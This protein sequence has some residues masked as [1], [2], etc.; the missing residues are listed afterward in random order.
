MK[1]SLDYRVLGLLACCLSFTGHAT[2]ATIFNPAVP[3]SSPSTTPFQLAANGQAL[4]PV[5]VSPS[6]S[7]ATKA[8]A[9]ELAEYLGRI[10]GAKFEVKSGDGSNGIVLGTLREFPHPELDKPLEIRDRF[11]GREAFAIR[12]ETKR[13][14]LI[15]AT[16]LGAS[17]AVFR[18]LE[19]LGCRWFFPAREWEVVPSQ[20][21]LSFGVNENSRPTL[22]AR[23]IW[24]GGGL[25]RDVHGNDGARS[26]YEYE[27]WKRHNRL[28][29]SLTMRNGHAWQAII[30]QN[31]AE[32]DKHPE[33]Y[34]LIQDK[35]GS[36]RRD[37]RPEAKL[38]VTNPAVQQMAVDYA[39]ETF[40][41][42]PD[43]EM[44]SMEPSDGGGWS[45]S[46]EAK[47]LGSISNQAYTLANIVA[48]AVQKEFPGKMVGMLAYGW[49][50]EPPTFPVEPNI[51]VQRT[52]GYTY[53][54]IPADQ[55]LA[56]WTKKVK[57]VGMYEYYSVWPWD[58]DRIP[59]GRGADIS[60][61]TQTIRQYA[62][63][64]LSS[65]TAESSSNWGVNGRGYYIASKL[66]W[67][68]Q[69]DVDA[70]LADFYDKAFGPAAAV[71]KRYYERL[72][73]GNHPLISVDLM[74][75]AFRDVQEAS[76]LAKDRPD[77]QARLDDLKQYLRFNYVYWRLDRT[78]DKAQRK[79]WSLE[80]LTD[81]YRGRWAYMTHWE[82]MRQLQTNRVAKEF[83]EPSWGFNNP[84]PD[85]PWH[86][87]TPLTHDETERKFQQGLEYFQPD[88][89]AEIK[90]DTNDLVPVEVPGDAVATS[91]SYQFGQ[92]FALS[93]LHGEAL[94]FSVATGLISVY[95]DKPPATYVLKDSNGQEITRGELPLDGEYHALS[96]RVPRAGTYEFDFDSSGAGWYLKAPANLPATL[97]LK[98]DE[99]LSAL[100]QLPTVYFYVPKGTREL[101]YFNASNRQLPYQV[102]GPDHKTLREVASSSEF[103]KIPVPPGMDGQF[104]SIVRGRIS[105]IWFFN[106]PNLLASSSQTYLMPRAL[107]LKDGWEIRH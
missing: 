87:Q 35:D 83:D 47:A 65:L 102:V 92:R 55:L 43:V 93:S 28:G 40:R 53:S 107:A 88:P 78:T 5:V 17:H 69:A 3:G 70:L 31:K 73:P 80:L 95:R 97:L 29:E 23:N 16:E 82:I 26:K 89:V 52:A 9:A 61:L 99:D 56:L 13:V 58:Y 90:F 37:V 7:P 75:Q 1:L 12:T 36:F 20:P 38:E 86:D 44:V 94:D 19:L 91:F 62:R 25:I 67:N 2:A 39:L 18:F 51:A 48:R 59:G 105:R 64:G 14:L 77:V 46:P 10:S 30:A 49:H 106:A 41:K 57:Y 96:L 74:A 27:A 66:M 15:G 63:V 21:A 45:V 8:V 32:F 54:K 76:T 98:H 60:Y 50:S 103:V 6:A 101:Q 71:M 33:Y 100:G 24:Y 84:A 34:A 68:P 22:L 72:D 85:K 4:A 79:A 81:A 11:D 42:H 104:W